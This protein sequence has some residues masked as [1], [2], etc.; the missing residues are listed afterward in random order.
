MQQ[1][2]IVYLSLGS[3]LGDK[4]KNL[5]NANKQLKKHKIRILKK[6]PVYETEPVGKINQPDFYNQV[7]KIKTELSPDDLLETLLLIEKDMGR[8]RIEKWGP[9]IIDIDILLYNNSIIKKKHLKIPHP[10]MHKRNFV[11]VPLNA[12]EKKLIH[13]VYNKPLN[14][15]IK[16]QAKKVKQLK[17]FFM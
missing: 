16:L 10:E 12:I 5:L 2:N 9:R 15:F 8:V 11:L 1:K 13:P 4:K 7:I 17:D 3:N 14:D 6:S